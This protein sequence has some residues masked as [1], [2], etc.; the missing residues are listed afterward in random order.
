MRARYAIHAL[1]M[2]IL[3]IVLAL[4]GCASSRGRHT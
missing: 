2:L 1:G 3:T 4:G